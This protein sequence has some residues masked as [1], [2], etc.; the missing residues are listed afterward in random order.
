MHFLA[1]KANQIGDPF[2]EQSFFMMVP[3]L[4]PFA[5]I[6]KR[7]ARLASNL[8]LFSRQPLSDDFSGRAGTGLQPRHPGRV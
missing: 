8:P 5:D 3:Y 7:T 1:D 4:Q 2:G 6:N